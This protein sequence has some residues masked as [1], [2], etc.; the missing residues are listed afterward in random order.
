MESVST[1]C[2]ASQPCPL[3]TDQWTLPSDLAVFLYCLSWLVLNIKTSFQT[4]FDI[5]HQVTS[6]AVRTQR[7]R[8]Q[9]TLDSAQF[10]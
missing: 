6:F 8:P 10:Y 7:D 9:Q 1:P 2:R 4:S 3:P 5:L